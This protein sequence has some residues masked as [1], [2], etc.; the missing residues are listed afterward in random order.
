M[1]VN[2]S[3]S[4]DF[5]YS[6][7]GRKQGGRGQRKG[8]GKSRRACII[9]TVSALIAT[10]SIRS[11]SLNSHQCLPCFPSPSSIYSHGPIPIRWLCIDHIAL[12]YHSICR[13]L[14]RVTMFRMISGWL[15]GS[16]ASKVSCFGFPPC[17]DFHS[18]KF[19]ASASTSASDHSVQTLYVLGVRPRRHK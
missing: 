17:A 7:V 16:R 10:H 11:S 5:V 6:T 13:C 15:R 19:D 3:V 8:S 12:L 4:C 18:F 1:K 9:L 2:N 14:G